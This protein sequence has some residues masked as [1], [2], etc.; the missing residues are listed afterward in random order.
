MEKTNERAS[1]RYFT[2][3][4]IYNMWASGVL[5]RIKNFKKENGI[6]LYTED[7]EL[8]EDIALAIR[9]AKDS[10]KKL[11]DFKW[12][13]FDEEH[14][15][16]IMP[17]IRSKFLDDEFSFH[18]I[19]KCKYDN[20]ET[21]SYSGLPSYDREY[22]CDTYEII[23]YMNVKEGCWFNPIIEEIVTDKVLAWRMY[24]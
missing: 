8:R 7:E 2:D 21:C 6:S 22:D 12:N 1:E 4:S 13:N 16:V 15:D 14:G 9:I 11:N 23:A 19:V 5:D 3:Q 18:V 24:K 17:P 10:M 20:S